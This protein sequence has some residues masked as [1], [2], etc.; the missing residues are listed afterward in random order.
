MVKLGKTVD[1]RLPGVLTAFVET[2]SIQLE[3]WISAAK[4]EVSLWQKYKSILSKEFSKLKAAFKK[5]LGSK[6]TVLYIRIPHLWNSL[7][8][9]SER[10]KQHFL[11]CKDDH[12]EDPA[13]DFFQGLTTS[14]FPWSTPVK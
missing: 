3:I 9:L 1:C 2:N 11:W 12:L 7:S 4:W 14:P 6:I 8:R 10:R 13:V 5:C